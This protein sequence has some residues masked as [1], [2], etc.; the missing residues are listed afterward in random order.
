MIRN[1]CTCS[2][3]TSL[4]KFV[5]D[6]VNRGVYGACQPDKIFREVTDWLHNHPNELPT[7]MV[8]MWS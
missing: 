4:N 3:H 5:I 7:H 1:H 2:H 8:V 6:Y